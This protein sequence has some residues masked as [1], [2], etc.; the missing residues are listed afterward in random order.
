MLPQACQSGIDAPPWSR[1]MNS[2]AA[3]E[4]TSLAR[5]SVQIRNS[6]TNVFSQ[7]SSPPHYNESPTVLVRGASNERNTANSSCM[8]ERLSDER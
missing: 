4:A 3:L 8:T 2:K 1:R 7:K 6:T 5:V